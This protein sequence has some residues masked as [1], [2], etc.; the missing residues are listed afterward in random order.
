MPK[1]CCIEIVC[2]V[3]QMQE[4]NHLRII[5]AVYMQPTYKHFILLRLLYYGN[6]IFSKYHCPVH[7]FDKFRHI[8]VQ[9]F[10]SEPEVYDSCDLFVLTNGPVFFFFFFFFRVLPKSK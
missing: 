8:F 6:G 7:E 5:N 4:D 10:A 3:S 9:K 2:F 1:Y